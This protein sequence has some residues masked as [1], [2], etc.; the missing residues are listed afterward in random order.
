MAAPKYGSKSSENPNKRHFFQWSGESS[1][2]GTGTCK[3]CNCK[4]QLKEKGP[5]G[6]KV[7]MYAKK[8][9]NAYTETEF[10]CVTRP[11]EQVAA[12]KAPVKKSGS[13]SGKGRKNPKAT[14]P[15]AKKGGT[16]SKSAPK[17]QTKKSAAPAAE[18]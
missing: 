17:K 1:G 6:G 11:A 13:K 9:T 15:G 18:A 7:R 12:A 16:R 5:R 3:Y 2:D 8:G 4:M 14:K 10:Q